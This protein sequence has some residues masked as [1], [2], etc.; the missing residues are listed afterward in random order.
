VAEVLAGVYKIER[1]IGSGGGGVVYLAKHLRLNKQVVLKGD[2]RSLTA[3]Q[4][5]LYR[6]VEILKTLG[7]TY[8]P[9]VYDYVAEKNVVFTVMDY[10][11]GE[12]LDKMLARG[13]RFAQA[14]IVAWAQQLLQAV[15]YLHEQ[16]PHGILHADIKPSNI[17][18]TPQDDIR[19]IDFNIALLLGE[20]GAI[21]VGRS[22][23]YASPEHYGIDYLSGSTTSSSAVG[24]GPTEFV[25]NDMDGT[26]TLTTS[27]VGATD[28]CRTTPE[29]TPVSSSS[30]SGK[31]KLLD[32]RSDVYSIGAT[33]YHLITGERP[34]RDATN[35][36]ST[37]HKHCSSALAAVVTK[38][39]NKNP[40]MRY[41]SANDMLRAVQNLRN[42]DPR[43]HQWKRRRLIACV[44]L[45]FTFIVG[46]LTAFSGWRL[47]EQ[48]LLDE[49]E[50]EVELQRVLAEEQRIEA[51][52]QRMEADAQRIEAELQRIEA[53]AQRAEARLQE[54]HVLA[55]NSTEALRS[56][57]RYGALALAYE[58][59]PCDISPMQIPEVRKALTDAL[60]IYDLS[61]GF[62]PHRTV[63]LPAETQN[64]AI[65]P[66]G[67]TF[68]AI[69]FGMLS[70]FH[71]ESGDL[72]AELGAIES[73]LADV[74]YVNDNMIIFAGENGVTAFDLVD[75]VMTWFGGYATTLAVSANRNTIAAVN[76][77]SATAT[78]YGIDGQIIGTVDFGEQYMHV[79][80]N[81]RFGNP[82]GRIFSLN[83]DGS[84][85]A[86]SFSGGGLEI[87]DVAGGQR[88]IIIFDYSEYTIFEGG[89]YG[90]YFAFSATSTE[91]S[92]FAV[93][94]TTTVEIT[95]STTLSGRIGVYADE[96]GV[97]MSY[98][99]IHVQIDP[100][101]ARQT[102]IHNDP[103]D[104]IAGEWRVDGNL[105]TPIVRIYRYGSQADK[106]IFAYDSEFIHDEARINYA[107][108][109]V[110]LF[111]YRH[112]RVY[113]I[114][115]ELLNE[116]AMQN[117][118]QIHDQLFRRNPNVS[119]LEVIYN[120]G[121]IRKYSAENGEFIGEELGSLPDLT[122]FEVFYT[123]TMR[124]ESTL[125]G[126]PRAY[127]LLTGELVRELEQVAFLTYVTEVGQY[128]ITEY[129]TA[130]GHRFGLLVD[131]QTAET[132]AYIPNLSDIIGD[133]L[134]INDRHTSTLRETRL[135]SM[136]EL[137]D[138]A[139][140]LLG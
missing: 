95:I 71:T 101:T 79:P 131:G 132:L 124:I 51:E 57:D 49:A 78:I 62:K 56:G 12:S 94:D 115:G 52:L 107:G 72:I 138:M 23:G 85:L 109:R 46:S 123:E 126:A 7:H 102:P 86:V 39:M 42:D 29:I 41:Q 4:D 67:E 105:N 50:R 69:S 122:L 108:D 116:T 129:I 64:L 60:G 73:G 80:V 43:V 92:L 121:T 28:V 136:S 139:R 11:E 88:G 10:V 21:A 140:I 120:D 30:V 14:R 81:D 65:A 137:I 13:E 134:I 55:L 63:A 98:N 38:A 24:E 110:M 53:D 1:E 58:A 22:F 26:E 61:D 15:A 127:N 90:N 76:R 133:R 91:E 45:A 5:T 104:H 66:N 114:S 32:A 87:F 119:Y 37:L 35:V 135:H 2:K 128:V 6:E 70:I 25:D 40:D 89:F 27:G 97:F 9:Q 75:R 106:A 82:G 93:I 31:K 48:A 74:V 3:S 84:L 19:L 96:S 125:H 16:P 20:D 77:D 117:P 118:S 100:L 68:A 111:S 59:L 36:A 103:H 18:L 8:I 44:V 34:N 112:F 54:R 130:D 99:R 113:D 33:L 83:Y 47:S 17:M